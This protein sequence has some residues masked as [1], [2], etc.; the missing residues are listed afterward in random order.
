VKDVKE[1]M[2]EWWIWRA[3]NLTEGDYKTLK[4]EV[5][6]NPLNHLW[7]TDS[8]Q[9]GIHIEGTDIYGGWIKDNYIARAEGV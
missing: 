3:I 7:I 1:S 8:D 5:I 9:D 4:T 6:R 2:V